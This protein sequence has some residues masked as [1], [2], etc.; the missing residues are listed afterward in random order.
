MKGSIAKCIGDLVT[1]KFGKQT[2]EQ[3]LVGA[4]MPASTV[5]LDMQNIPDEQVIRLVQATMQ[6]TGL[7]MTAVAD[8]FGDHWVNV[9]SQ[10]A[11][12]H[13]YAKHSNARDFLLAMNDLHSSIMRRVENAHPPQFEYEWKDAKT[14]NLKYK[15][16]RNLLDI[17]IG[18]VKGVGKHYNESLKVRKLNETSIEVVFP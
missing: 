5:I 17:V 13:M 7:S 3:V 16:S 18:L 11:Y 10:M 6:K 4:G 12:A 15:S 8:A 2:W 1:V 9:Y 14:L